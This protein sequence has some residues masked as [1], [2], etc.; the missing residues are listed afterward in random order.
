MERESKI[1][2]GFKEEFAGI[3]NTKNDPFP[4]ANKPQLFGPLR[5]DR[6]ETKTRNFLIFR[7]FA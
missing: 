1:G 7:L 3:A 4:Y 6:W 2:S 5:L